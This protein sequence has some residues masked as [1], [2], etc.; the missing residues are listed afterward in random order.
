MSQSEELRNQIKGYAYAVGFDRVGFCAASDLEVNPLVR[1]ACA[2]DRCHQYGRNWVCPP[3]CDTLDG[4]A[5]KFAARQQ[6]IVVQTAGILEDE[7]D[8]EGMMAAEKIHKQHFIALVDKV[9]AA[10]LDGSIPT[11]DLSPSLEEGSEVDPFI[12]LAAGACT[13]CPECTYP[14]TPC[15]FPK[16]AFVS[17]EASGL[18]VSE[19]CEKAGLSYYDGPSTVTYSSCLV[20]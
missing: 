17:M 5:A 8:F 19:V 4:Y 6:V 3:A 10:Q 1:D 18:V 12:F 15:R 14:N 2:A 13:I 16:R 9:R 7:Y 11:P 20:Y